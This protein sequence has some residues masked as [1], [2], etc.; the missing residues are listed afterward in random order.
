MQPLDDLRDISTQWSQLDDANVFVLRYTNAIETYLRRL[1]RDEDVARDVLQ[2]FLL[3]VLERGFERAS[4]DKG[5]FRF[6]LI[7]AVHNAAISYQRDSGRRRVVD[8]AQLPETLAS[9]SSELQSYWQRDWHDCILNRAWQQLEHH[10][11]SS[12]QNLFFSILQ[13][14]T[15]NPE[16][17]S[18]ALA[19]EVAGLAGREISPATFRQQ[20]SRARKMFARLIVEEVAE[21]LE[22]PTRESIVEELS[23]VGLLP[24]VQEFLPD[25]EE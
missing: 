20:L 4:P 19:A 2:A 3:R 12:E 21:T 1:L 18:R 7:R 13:A 17:D 25:K 5:K 11:A 6:Y 10:Q 14:S 15:Q 9:A 16:L 24:Y 8:I 22:N 23:D